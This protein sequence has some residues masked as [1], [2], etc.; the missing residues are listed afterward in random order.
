MIT[1]NPLMCEPSDA[2]HRRGDSDEQAE[3]ARRAA[4]D[5]ADHAEMPAV[6]DDM[7]A[8]GAPW[9]DDDETLAAARA[10]ADA[11]ARRYE[12]ELRA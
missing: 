11:V 9:P 5:P 8:L 4:A 6:R 3:E 1:D 12:D 10:A 2:D 7:D